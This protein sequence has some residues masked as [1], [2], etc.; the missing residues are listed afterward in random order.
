MSPAHNSNAT[1]A[2]T[3]A[4]EAGKYRPRVGALQLDVGKVDTFDT[5]VDQVRTELAS[6]ETDRF[7]YLVNNAGVWHTG[8]LAETTV[9]DL[10]RLYAVN[11]RGVFF[12]TEKLVP[13]I[14]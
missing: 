14:P 5:F 1:A 10:D 7:D 11:V 9:E 4:A 8:S 6:L 12:I 2:E 13:L 3:V